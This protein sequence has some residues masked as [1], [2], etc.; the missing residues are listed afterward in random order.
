MLRIVGGWLVL[1]LVGSLGLAQD[2][3]VDRQTQIERQL[4]ELEKQIEQVRELKFKSPVV[5]KVIARP[6]EGAEGVQAYYD[7]KQKTIFL[8]DDIKDNYQ[9]GVLIHEMVHA[10]Q[11]QHFGLSKLHANTFDS[12][13]ELAL[14]ALIEGDA[15]LT[16]IEL[17]KKEQPHVEKMLLTD[18]T[19][20][21]NLQRAF[22]YGVGTRFV[23]EIKKKGGWKA[24]DSR[25]RFTPTSTATILHPNERLTPMQLGP[26]KQVGEFGLIQLLHAAEMTRARSVS[27]ASGWRGDRRVEDEHGSRWVV[28]FDQ[29][30]QAKR[31]FSALCDLRATEYPKKRPLT[32][33]TT[34]W[35]LT[36]EAGGKHGILLR[37]KRVWEVVAKHEAGYRELLDQLEGPPRLTVYSTQEKKF[38]TFGEFLD[39]LMGVDLIC[40]GESHDSE[41]HHQ[42]QLM[43][44]KGLF[45]RDE[46]LG[47]GMEMFQRPFQKILDRYL[48]GAINEE[49]FLEDTEYKKRWGY[50]WALYRPIVEFC[51]R[52]QIPLA[53]LNLSDE[54]RA[55]LRKS[56]YDKL[57]DEDKKLLGP[58]DFQVKA[59]RDHWF[60][61]LGSMHGHGEM[62]PQAKEQFYQVMTAWDEYMADSAARFQQ[63]RKLRR[64]VVLAGSGHIEH[65]FGIP[66]R[67][68]K[69]T[70][71]KVATVT[72]QYAQGDKPPSKPL[73]DFI[74][75]A[76]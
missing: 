54:L 16:M 64:L 12:D 60:D 11:D 1:G 36:D 6:A 37:D 31:F 59:H 51:R 74:V 61:Q 43:I 57:S 72:I 23:A 24:V 47:V 20:A 62:T 8:Y 27:A 55:R 35:L 68:A 25:Y 5:A 33:T 67:A 58:I 46:R 18:L 3:S 26:G 44:L 19:K 13:R 10:L 17:L 48:A 4:R 30:D 40:V 52:N 15:Q 21:K 49:T 29:A 7:P 73:A 41:L 76:K 45:A 50:D 14:A 28:V 63:E 53:A 66:D 38:L 39:R 2:P 42:V 75:L 56:G 69:R 32:A 71:G 34:E 65:G 22:L 70:G 9:K